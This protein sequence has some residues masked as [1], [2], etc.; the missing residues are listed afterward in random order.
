MLFAQAATAWSVCDRLDRSPVLAVAAA[1]A[2][3]L[4]AAWGDA[5]CHETGYVPL[6]VQ[7]C[8]SDVQ[9]IEQAVAI[10]IPPASQTR[11]LRLAH[12]E[13]A[14]SARSASPVRSPSTS[15]GPPRRIL[16]Q[17]FQV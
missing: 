16:L 12:P 1:S 3:A 10:P 7:H 17:S 4:A 11:V 13:Q 2:A 6:C 14:F 9:A 8:L 5:P 15:T